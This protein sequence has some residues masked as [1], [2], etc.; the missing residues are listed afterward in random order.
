M[1]FEQTLL[2]GKVGES[3]IANWFKRRGYSIL[4]VYEIE[5][6][7]GKGPQLFMPAQ[8]LIAPD[9]LIFNAEKILWV[10]TKHKNAFTLHRISGDWTTGIDQRHYHDYCKVDEQTPFPVWILFLQRG[11]HAKDSPETSPS[12]L[13]GNS[14][15][16]LKAHEHHRHGNWG[17]SGMVYW[18]IR[19]LYKIADLEDIIQRPDSQL[20]QN[21]EF[22]KIA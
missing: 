1:S 3:L 10:E 18:G 22:L 12:G 4:P 11:G 5:K 17:N 9:M 21:T 13:F 6:N 14:I 8:E 19:D 16:Y 7:Q 20:T 2:R 15:R